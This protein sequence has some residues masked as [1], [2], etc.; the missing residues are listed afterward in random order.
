MRDAVPAAEV[1]GID[2]H[3]IRITMFVP[4]AMLG[5]LAGSLFMHYVSFV[6]VQSF[7]VERSIVFLLAPVVAG[8]RSVYGVVLGALCGS[9][10]GPAGA[11][12]GRSASRWMKSR[13]L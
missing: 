6:N 8:A 2:M 9:L 13:P 11:D 5:S 10:S 3:G 4:S 12:P 1:L 7:T